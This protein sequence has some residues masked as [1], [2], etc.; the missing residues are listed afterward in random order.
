MVPKPAIRV[1]AVG[2]GA[3]AKKHPHNTNNGEGIQEALGR[4]FWAKA[5][6]MKANCP[7]LGP[8]QFGMTENIIWLNYFLAS[9]ALIGAL[10][11]Y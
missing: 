4:N 9:A 10:S 8:G 11:M 5:H 3:H 1:G 2:G 6:S 7:G